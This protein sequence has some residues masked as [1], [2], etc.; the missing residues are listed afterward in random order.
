MEHNDYQG[1]KYSRKN[2]PF[3]L[4]FYEAFMAKSD[5]TKQEL[6]YKSGYGREILRDKIINSLKLLRA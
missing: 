1:G 6:F 2:A 4:V 5:A 3:E